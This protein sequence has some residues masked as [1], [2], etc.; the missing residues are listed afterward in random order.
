MGENKNYSN[1]P[2][3]ALVA[4]LC[5]LMAIGMCW[6]FVVR[7][8][9]PVR[10]RID[11]FDLLLAHWRYRDQF[12]AYVAVLWPKM[13]A[14]HYPYYFT[15]AVLPGVLM[16]GAAFSLN[17]RTWDGLFY[18]VLGGL[19]GALIGWVLYVWA[20]FSN[21]LYQAWVMPITALAVGIAAS[22]V[23]TPN[24]TTRVVRGTRILPHQARSGKK[25]L[26]QAVKRGRT[27]IAGVMLD[28]EAETRHFAAL[29]I[30][31]SGKSTALRELMYTAVQRG[32]R[33][34]VA[35][36]DGGAMRVFYRQGDVV[37][38][39]F[40]R[41]S[42]KWDI[43]AEIS[44]ESDY[45]FI[46]ESVLPYTGAR[47]HDQWLG[48][49]Q[50]IFAACLRTWHENALGASDAFLTALATASTEKIAKL[51]EGSAAQRYFE[52]SNERMLS[53]VMSTLAPALENVKPMTWLQGAPFSVR[54]WLNE[55]KGSLW[56][57]YRASQIAALRGLIACWMRLAIFEG[58]SLA[59]SQERRIWYHLDELDALGRIEGLKD[60]QSRLRKF[61]GCVV[62]GFQSIAQVR[63][64]YNSAD[65]KTI[66]ENC[67]NKLI[68]RC[69]ES[70]G[71]GTARFASEIIG[72]REIARDEMTHSRT[73][74]KHASRTHTTHIHQQTE[75]AILPSEV[76]QL[77]DC[78]GYLKVSTHPHWMRVRFD[79][80]L[81]HPRTEAYLPARVGAGTNAQ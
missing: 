46:A 63:A 5:A 3:F 31:G 7:Y 22:A 43:L 15:A 10:N 67:G 29:G 4:F 32:D 20:P 39:P 41:R 69:E 33:H 8:W 26:E 1:E 55:G 62:I 50:Q 12:S 65:A 80:I 64:V 24:S 48:H 73:H 51:C 14:F 2:P 47:D 17:R 60:A 53:S 40:D 75:K 28:R 66:I 57:P 72:E 58:L 6:H 81:F 79:P 42:A 70:E 11:M 25:M 54:R 21:A 74:G 18:A 56:M 44:E 16:Q 68:L 78:T 61:G 71:G 27:A 9:I 49:A 52:S 38:N 59:P 45:R 35:D 37:L 76:M 13:I 23:L 34:V 30:T 19:G 77:P 36:P